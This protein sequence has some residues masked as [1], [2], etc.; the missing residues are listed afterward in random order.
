MDNWEKEK[1]KDILGNNSKIEKRPFRD[2]EEDVVTISTKENIPSHII[3]NLV[4]NGY[5]MV[6]KNHLLII[7]PNRYLSK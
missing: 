6:I 5:N 1:L 4:C 3:T 7:Y 2:L